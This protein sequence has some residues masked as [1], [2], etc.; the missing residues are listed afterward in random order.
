MPFGTNDFFVHT[1]EEACEELGEHLRELLSAHL[2]GLMTLKCVEGSLKD[3]SGQLRQLSREC[4]TQL[5]SFGLQTLLELT[6]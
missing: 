5:L 4:F 1:A 3:F 6:G 2:N